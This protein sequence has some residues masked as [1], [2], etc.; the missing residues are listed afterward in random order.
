MSLPLFR[1]VRH[2]LAPS[3]VLV[4]MSEVNQPH[5]TKHGISLRRC[6][7]DPPWWHIERR[8]DGEKGP[9]K[10]VNCQK[11]ENKGNISGCNVKDA[12]PTPTPTQQVYKRLTAGRR[13]VVFNI[14]HKRG[15]F[16][17]RGRWGTSSLLSVQRGGHAL[18]LPAASHGCPTRDRSRM[19]FFF[20]FL[21]FS[22]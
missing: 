21:L 16:D 2:A 11:G 5:L 12:A 4:S 9:P 13:P 15:V 19:F 17:L 3:L 20:L 8:R 6:K 18:P 7:R 22:C 10:N 1:S 14:V